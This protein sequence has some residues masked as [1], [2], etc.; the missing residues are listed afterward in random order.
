M[1]NKDSK[2]T[3]D[4]IPKEDKTTRVSWSEFVEELTGTSYNRI[5]KDHLNKEVNDDR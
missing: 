3:D 2:H 4:F 5:F 1:K